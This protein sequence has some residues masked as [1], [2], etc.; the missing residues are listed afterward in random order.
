MIFTKDHIFIL[1]LFIIF[2]FSLF[3]ISCSKKTEDI[4]QKIEKKSD[5]ISKTLG[6]DVD[7]VMKRKDTKDSIFSSVKPTVADTTK[8]ASA[9]FRKKINKIFSH[10]IDIKNNLAKD[11]S[12]TVQK[13]VIEMNE[14]LQEAGI[15]KGSEKLDNWSS[16]YSKLKM[17]I[18]DIDG[19]ASLSKQRVLFSDLTSATLDF[20]KKYGLY[21]K[22][23]YYLQCDKAGAVKNAAWLTESK[24]TDNPYFG[25]DRSNEK[26]A[27]CYKLTGAWKFD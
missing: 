22:T 9:D 16:M 18:S 20:I 12:E 6:R 4:T 8:L 14:A 27:P 26:S 10:Y 7:S 25:K 1:I 19:A 11:D 23:I 24:D 2:F 15:K 17:I 5:T 3:I 13:H 21:D